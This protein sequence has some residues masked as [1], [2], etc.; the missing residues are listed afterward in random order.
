MIHAIKTI[1]NDIA[2]WGNAVV[3]QN[4]RRASIFLMI[5]SGLGFASMG[6]VIVTTINMGYHPAQT[7]FFRGV[8]GTLFC[9]PVCIALYQKSQSWRCFVA[10]N[11]IAM[12]GRFLCSGLGFVCSTYAFAYITM[13]EFSAISFMIP[14]FLTVAGALF[15]AEP[16]GIRRISA[17]V[18]GFIGVYIIINPQSDGVSIGHAFAIGFLLFSTGTKISGKILSKD[19]PTTL[20]VIYITVGVML[21]GGLF[22]IPHLQPIS[23]EAVLMIFLLGLFGHIGQWALTKSMGIGE[24]SVIMPFDYLKLFYGTF[25]G[26]IL[27]GQIPPENMWLGAIF[28]IGAA[29]YTSLRERTIQKTNPKT[30]TQK[31]HTQKTPSQKTMDRHQ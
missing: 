27:F 31:T 15:F 11:K 13:A 22:A 20:N 25:Y 10:N 6:A 17:V 19:I 21:V 4:P 14:M 18:V 2:L 1:Y 24:L 28:I 16:V 7:A 26:F 30:P 9:L 29:L 12:G 8:G 23:G 3:E 5:L